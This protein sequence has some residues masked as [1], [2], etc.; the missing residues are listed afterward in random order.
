MH[1][2]N[3]E[4]LSWEAGGRPEDGIWSYLWY[5]NTHE[6]TGFGR[7]GGATGELVKPAPPIDVTALPSEA[8]D[9]IAACL[10]Y[11]NRLTEA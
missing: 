3:T 4:M 7:G 2:R 1:L 11:Y 6:S 5:K 9:V 10:P 8:Q